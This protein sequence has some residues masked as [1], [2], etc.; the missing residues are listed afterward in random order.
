[1]TGT[2][3]PVGDRVALVTGAASGIGRAT[4]ELLVAEGARVAMA[5]IDVDVGR[6]VAAGLHEAPGE[7]WFV[8]CD[9]RSEAD[10]GAAVD[11]ALGRWGRLDGL[12]CVAGGAQ[13]RDIC[14][15]DLAFF[16]DQIDF[17]LT[18]TFR[19][20]RKAL[21]VMR[22]QRSGSVVTVS[23]GWGFRAAPG[24]AAYAAA[25]AG[26]VGFTR[27]MAA[28]GSAY[29]VRANVVAPGAVETERMRRLTTGD[30]L[31]TVAQAAIPLGRP[32]L[33]A[34]VA[35]VIAFLLSARASYVTGQVVHVNGGLHMP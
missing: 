31:S 1:V 32:G 11:G 27:A 29:G 14:D 15:M 22:D 34:E 16:E 9:V 6:Q 35:E 17:N 3:P 21:P 8:P 7:A 10:V 23:S 12:V 24:R 19:C 25:K 30:Q 20:C 33:P 28:E 13:L 26:L 5:D 18:S 2:R 4:A